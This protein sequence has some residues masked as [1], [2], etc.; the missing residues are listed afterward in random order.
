MR[1]KRWRR[2]AENVGLALSVVANDLC[3]H[4]FRAEIAR[5]SA[6]GCNFRFHV[7]GPLHLFFA[8]G[9][10]KGCPDNQVFSYHAGTDSP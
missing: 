2:I 10:T 5:H 7:A 4:A 8:L 6:R 3:D 1:P 9:Q